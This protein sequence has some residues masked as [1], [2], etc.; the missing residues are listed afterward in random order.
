MGA[1]AN[2]RPRGSYGPPGWFIDGVDQ[3]VSRGSQDFYAL[4][5]GRTLKAGSTSCRL[6][7]DGLTCENGSGH[8]FF[9]NR[10]TAELR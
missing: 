10:A 5:Y 6:T 9:V 2:N 4:S 3:I 8:G 7:E 1:W